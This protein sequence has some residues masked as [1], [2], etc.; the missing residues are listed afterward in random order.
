MST[1]ENLA[2][3]FNAL[4]QNRE[5]F[6]LSKAVKSAKVLLLFYPADDTP[7]CTSQ[8]ADFRDHASEFEKLGIQIYGISISSNDSQAEFHQ[9]LQLNFPLLADY[10]TRITRKYKVMSFTGHPKRALFLIDENRQILWH[11]VEPVAL[12]RRSAEE[13]LGEIKTALGLPKGGHGAPQHS[14]HD[15]SHDQEHTQDGHG[16]AEHDCCGHHH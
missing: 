8:L 5:R 1:T 12:F 14:G 2:P 13:V 15:K 16:D 4:N 6:F 9:K 3:D 11:H 10:D 7:V